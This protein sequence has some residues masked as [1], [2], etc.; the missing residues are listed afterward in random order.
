M[1]IAESKRARPIRQKKLFSIVRSHSDIITQKPQGFPGGFCLY[2]LLFRPFQTLIL[3]LG[4]KVL[5]F[6]KRFG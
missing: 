2:T 6:H 1:T 5:H 4:A 3:T